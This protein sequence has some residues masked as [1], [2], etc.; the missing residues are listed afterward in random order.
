VNT[1][2][3][4]TGAALI[5]LAIVTCGRALAGADADSAAVYASSHELESKR[6]YAD[7]LKVLDLVSP[8]D[9]SS[10]FF[11]LRCAWLNYCN[12]RYDEAA[13]GYDKAARTTP[14][15]LEPLVGK[16]LAESALNKWDDVEK[17]ALAIAKAD[18]GNYTARSSLAYALFLRRR[19]RES[20]DA[21]E[22]VLKL[23]PC[24]LTMQAGLGWALLW[25]GK[26]REAVKV[27]R[28]IL[29]ISP[30]NEGAARAIGKDAPPTPSAS[31]TAYQRSYQ[32]EAEGNYAEG[33]KALDDVGA[34]AKQTYVYNLRCGWL[35]YLLAQHDKSAAAYA[36]AAK[37]APGAVQPL[38]GKVQPEMALAKWDDAAKTMEAAKALD[39]RNYTVRSKLAY[40]CYFLNRFQ[41]AER[42]Y[43]EIL[44][45]YPGDLAARSGLAWSQLKLDKKADAIREFK[46]ILQV[47]PTHELA[48]K[49][50]EA[51]QAA[52]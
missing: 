41:D 26:R 27:F 15:T 47:Y 19:Y 39:P 7:A 21:Y 4:L 34:D 23:Y 30:A 13:L 6:Q 48:T 33:L 28:D 18:P 35:N 50:L 9:K 14:G 49:G 42:L 45:E 2:R 1:L 5:A 32:A 51:A 31:A 43:Q 46:S 12:G 22:G 29:E 25:Q 3:R 10:Y 16:I 24:D 37:L 40:A 36:V 52:K 20:Q 38:L 44:R 8:K 17:T 11:L